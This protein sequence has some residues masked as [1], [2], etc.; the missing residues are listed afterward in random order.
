METENRMTVETVDIC[1]CGIV[2]HQ[3][4]PD[5]Y[6][7][8]GATS[9]VCCPACGNEVFQTIKQLQA[10]NKEKQELIDELCS[11]EPCPK[12]GCGVTGQCL[13][14]IIKQLQAE[15]EHLVSVVEATRQDNADYLKGTLEEK[16]KAKNEKLAKLLDDVMCEVAV[17]CILKYTIKQTLKENADDEG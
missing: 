2:M 8:L 3:D 12:C 4:N 9:P 1:T 7:T 17:S 5:D 14:C 13:G 15:R 11:Q 6:D 10:K 16:L